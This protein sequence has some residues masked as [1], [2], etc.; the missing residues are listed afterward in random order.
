MS[1][2]STA[3]SITD[4]TADTMSGLGRFLL[5]AEPHR[6]PVSRPGLE[7]GHLQGVKRSA[8]LDALALA[9]LEDGGGLIGVKTWSMRG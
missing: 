6:A 9:L 5:G 7:E 1:R 4:D 8:F 3:Q 2:C